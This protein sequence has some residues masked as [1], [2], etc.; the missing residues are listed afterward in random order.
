MKEKVLLEINRA[1]V[2][3]DF[4]SLSDEQ[5]I[6]VCERLASIES[7]LEEAAELGFHE[8]GATLCNCIAE[9][10]SLLT[11]RICS[12]CKSPRP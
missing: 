5:Y 6:I 11:G 4:D 8:D 10:P 3:L 12:E 9:K 7:A 2:D 1:R